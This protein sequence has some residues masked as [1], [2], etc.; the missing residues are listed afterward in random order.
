MPDGG[1]VTG[2]RVRAFLHR[3]TLNKNG[4]KDPP[5][6][7][8]F[9]ASSTKCIL[10]ASWKLSAMPAVPVELVVEPVV[11]PFLP[12]TKLDACAAQGITFEFEAESVSK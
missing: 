2:R 6:H 4:T 3:G 11:C 5:E 1:T 10:S 9:D 7:P 12:S 8:S